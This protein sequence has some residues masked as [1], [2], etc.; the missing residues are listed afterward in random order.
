MSRI[1]SFALLALAAA[2]GSSSAE[3]GPSLQATVAYETGPAYILQNDGEYGAAGTRYG[4]DDVGQQDNLA[5]V[6]RTSLELA[7][8]RHRAVFLYAPFEAKTTVT[9]SRDLSFRDT[10]FV[11]GTVVEHRYLFDGYRASYLYRLLDKEKVSLEVGGSLQVRNAEV[12]FDSQDGALRAAENDIGLVFA[13]KARLWY[14][15]AIDSWWAAL[16]ADGFSTFGLV[17]GVRGAIY[18]VQLAAGH[19][20]AKGVDVVFGARLLGGGAKVE[21]RDIYNWA[22]FIA[23]TAGVR[24]SLDHVLGRAARNRGDER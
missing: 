2:S 22:N 16:D 4:A 17:P 23:L 19:P 3:P 7:Y 24:V 1:V 5:L 9:L 14:R 11:A 20:V 15:P 21:D 8:G 10:M 12:A 6:S 13:A 18:D